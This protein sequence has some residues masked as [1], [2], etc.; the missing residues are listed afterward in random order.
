[1][2]YIAVNHLRGLKITQSP[3]P[4]E[5]NNV[6]VVTPKEN[7][8]PALLEAFPKSCCILVSFLLPGSNSP[9]LGSSVS[10]QVEEENITFHN[11]GNQASWMQFCSW[12]D[13][14]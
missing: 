10:A 11:S 3:H 13:N 12:Q 14:P 2:N 6:L 7:A 8:V 5:G 1:M 4:Q 9:F